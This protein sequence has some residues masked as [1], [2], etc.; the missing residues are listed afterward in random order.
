VDYPSGGEF[1]GWAI[2]TLVDPCRS[3]S[4]VDNP[5]VNETTIIIFYSAD[6]GLVKRAQNVVVA[7]CTNNI[8]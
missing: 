5:Q 6:S 7:L 2:C 8:K 4:L 3:N 1:I